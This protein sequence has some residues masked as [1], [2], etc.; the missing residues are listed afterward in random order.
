M[1]LCLG[2]YLKTHLK[3]I[4]LSIEQQDLKLTKKVVEDGS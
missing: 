3:K 1:I 2:L 4:I